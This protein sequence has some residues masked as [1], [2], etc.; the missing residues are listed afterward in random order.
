MFEAKVVGISL[1]TCFTWASSSSEW[2]LLLHTLSGVWVSIMVFVLVGDRVLWLNDDHARSEW[3][4]SHA[5][6]E[7]LV[8][9]EVLLLV[10]EVLVHTSSHL[11][12]H[13]VHLLCLVLLLLSLEILVHCGTHLLHH[14]VLLGWL[15]ILVVV[16]SDRQS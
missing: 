16:S 13:W 12:H 9:I 4:V 1:P 11:L 14:W 2:I 15:G 8:R 7:L 3:V 10:L 5:T 6:H